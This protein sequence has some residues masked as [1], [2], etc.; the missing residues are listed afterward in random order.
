MTQSVRMVDDSG[1]INW[2]LPGTA[3]P[4]RV[5]GPAIINPGVCEAWC[6]YGKY[7]RTDGPAIIYSSGKVMW[8]INGRSICSSEEFR[9]RAKLTNDD[10]LI[11][12]LKYGEIEYLG[13]I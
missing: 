12:T 7:H 6:R 3:M 4:H 9:R 10:M 2:V 1:E 11:L 8:F 5:D 13:S